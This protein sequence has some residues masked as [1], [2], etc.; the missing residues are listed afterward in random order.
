V[1]AAVH[2]IDGARSQQILAAAKER[3]PVVT[4]PLAGIA[5]KRL[6]AAGLDQA[7]QARAF[8]K[9][10]YPKGGNSVILGMHGL[11]ENL[12][13]SEDG[14]EEFERALMELGLHFGFRAQRPEKDDIWKLDVLWAI[15]NLEYLLFP[16]KSEATSETISKHYTDEVG[17]AINW[18]RK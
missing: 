17:G 5:Y 3:N 1:A 11:L 6:D 7:Q 12:V 9:A 14:S 8:L 15:G 16:C 18:F 10:A 2:S 13:F 4:R